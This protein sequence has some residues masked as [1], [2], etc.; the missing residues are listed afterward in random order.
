[1]GQVLH[2][3]AST[4]AASVEQCKLIKR[5]LDAGQASRDQRENGQPVWRSR[6]S[7]ADV[8]PGPKEAH[9]TVLTVE[10]A[11]I[12]VA[13]R[14]HALIPL[15]DRLHVLQSAIPNQTGS[16]LRRCLQRHDISRLPEYGGT[17]PSEASSAAIGPSPPT[18]RENGGQCRKRSCQ[19]HLSTGGSFSKAARSKAI[20]TKASKR[21]PRSKTAAEHVH[22]ASPCWRRLP[23]YQPHIK[24]LPRGS[25]ASPLS[26]V[27]RYV[28]T[29]WPGLRPSP[30]VTASSRRRSA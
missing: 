6:G 4:T 12:I 13:F 11:P 29:R 21:V 9:S 1:M 30:F 27:A 2:G 7:T 24:R 28:F 15:D 17:S 25:G 14:K 23:H 20:P 8:L 10:E 18:A 26:L 3:S 16:S 22:W 19:A 5:P